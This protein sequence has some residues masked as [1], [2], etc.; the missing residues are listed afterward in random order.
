MQVMHARVSMCVLHL[1][2][3]S[4]NGPLQRLVQGSFVLLV[5]LLGNLSLLALNFEL[6][7]FFLQR[8]E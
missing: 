1:L 3:F 8:F 2:C 4:L 6:K 5:L 7:E